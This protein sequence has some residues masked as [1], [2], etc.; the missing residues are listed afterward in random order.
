MCA[1]KKETKIK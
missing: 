1:G